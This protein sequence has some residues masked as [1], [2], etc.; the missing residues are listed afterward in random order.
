MISNPMIV[1]A[2]L[3][4]SFGSKVQ[5]VRVCSEEVGAPTPRLNRSTSLPNRDSL[6][7]GYMLSP[8]SVPFAALQGL[9]CKVQLQQ[10][11]CP[12][13]YYFHVD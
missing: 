2:A 5:F 13:Q 1:Y 6:C 11:S 3:N 9:T 10:H 8:T 4:I 12:L 7:S